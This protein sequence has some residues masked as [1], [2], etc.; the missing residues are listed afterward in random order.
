MT[1]ETK[2]KIMAFH[3]IEWKFLWLLSQNEFDT[4]KNKARFGKS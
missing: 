2:Q 4:M 3:I 1:N